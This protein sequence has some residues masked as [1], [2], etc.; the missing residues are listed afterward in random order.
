VHMDG[1]FG[2]GTPLPEVAHGFTHFRLQ[3]RPLRWRGVAPRAAV[4]DNDDLRW[5][6]PAAI[7]ALGLPA[8]IRRLLQAPP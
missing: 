7:A 4:R 8:P 3:L 5:T 6:P 1:D 2:H